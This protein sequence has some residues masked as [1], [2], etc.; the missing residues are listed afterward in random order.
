VA[1]AVREGTLTEDGAVALIVA[2]F[3]GIDEAAAKRIVAAPATAPT[4]SIALPTALPANEGIVTAAD[5]LALAIRP[6]VS[7]IGTR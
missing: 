1:K 4:G 5:P 6:A 7:R 3:G 2:S